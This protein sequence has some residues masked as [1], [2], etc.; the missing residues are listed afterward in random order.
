RWSAGPRAWPGPSRPRRPGAAPSLRRRS[1][2]PEPGDRLALPD[3]LATVG[4]HP[5]EEAP[6]RAADGGGG[7]RPLDHADGLSGQNQ[8]TCLRAFEVGLRQRAED[9]D[10]GRNDHALG[11]GENLAGNRHVFN[12]APTTERGAMSSGV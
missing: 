4:E 2:Q 5:D 7:A 10:S 9:T 6:E 8:F 1:R 3:A 11:N 12:D